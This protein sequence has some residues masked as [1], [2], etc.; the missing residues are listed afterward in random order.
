MPGHPPAGTLL[1]FG[2][3][4]HHCGLRL[5]FAGASVAPELPV[6]SICLLP[7][8]APAQLNFI[9]DFVQQLYLLGH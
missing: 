2:Q 5:V 7:N 6:L 3:V 9:L 1:I 8:L 4:H